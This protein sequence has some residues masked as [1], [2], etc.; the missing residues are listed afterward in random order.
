MTIDVNRNEKNDKLSYKKVRED[1]K[2]SGEK[3]KRKLGFSDARDLVKSHEVSPRGNADGNTKTV[4]NFLSN[5]FDRLK[6]KMWKQ[7]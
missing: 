4:G 5:N 3:K 6:W 7:P 1:K 2:K